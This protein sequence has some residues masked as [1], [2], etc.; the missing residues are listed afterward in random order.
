MSGIT[1]GTPFEVDSAN[2][3][4]RLALEN[5]LPPDTAKLVW[6][7]AAMHDMRWA[8]V[9]KQDPAVELVAAGAAA[10]VVG[11]DEGMISEAAT[12]EVLEV[13]PRLGFKV[14]FAQLLTDHCRRKPLSQIGT[15]L[16]G[17]CRAAVPDVAF[18]DPMAGI[19]SAPYDR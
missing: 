14:H 6:N 18:P 4:E 9:E 17:Y 19:R 5:G 2:A 13:F 10:D 11:P 12:T 16:D 7:A 8:V 15:W 1:D 3:A